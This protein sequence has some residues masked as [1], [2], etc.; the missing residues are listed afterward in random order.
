MSIVS[1]GVDALKEIFNL[2]NFND[3][4]VVR[5]QIDGILNVSCESAVTKLGSPGRQSFVK[6]L[7]I[8]IDLDEDKFEGSS[9]L[10]FSTVLDHFFGLY[11]TINSFTQLTV[12][13]RQREKVLL[14][15]KPR[16]GK[17]VLV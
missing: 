7:A 16:A 14:K 8:T 17:S 1:N 15:C 6:G 11:A 3:S 10:L 13:T 9:A 4:S 5:N 2:Y 12:T